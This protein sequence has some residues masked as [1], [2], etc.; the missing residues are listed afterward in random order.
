MCL[1]LPDKKKDKKKN[2]VE[3][4]VL[5][6]E[7]VKEPETI[8]IPE[9]VKEIEKPI[10]YVLPFAYLFDMGSIQD[11]FYNKVIQFVNFR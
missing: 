3:E 11:L 4:S 8:I 7:S 1:I 2:K 10:E 5:I 6:D 9:P